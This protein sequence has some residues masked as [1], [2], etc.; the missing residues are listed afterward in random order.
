MIVKEQEIIK[1]LCEENERGINLLLQ[2]YG[3]LIRYIIA[4]ILPNPQDQEECLSEVTMRVW[5]KIY[6]FDRQRG[7]FNTWLTAIA[8]NTALNHQ[9]NRYRNGE[10]EELHE[11]IP[12][13]ERTP[14]ETVIQ[15]EREA[16]I[17]RA[18]EQLAPKE[19]MLFYRRFYYMQS[20][21]QIASELGTSERAIE[22]KIY[23]LKKKLRKLLGGEVHE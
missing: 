6:Q 5:E 4:P 21:A 16:A 14:E 17:S 20:T 22:G 1:L 2:H 11:K 7:S 18:V 13:S 10:T 23:R 15:L 3:P 19:K 8:R 12:S 9:R